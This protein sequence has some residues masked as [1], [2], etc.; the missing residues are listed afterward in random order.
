[1]KAALPDET[2]RRAMALFD[3]LSERGDDDGFRRRLLTGES[4]AVLARVA[5][6]ESSASSAGGMIPT[7]L[8]DTT[9]RWRAPPSQVGAFRVTEL[10]GEGGMG[11][12]WKA[13]RSDGLYD[14]TVAIKVMHAF[15]TG[16]GNQRF[17]AER[18]ILARLEHPHIARLIDGGVLQDGAPFLVMEYVDGLALDVFAKDLPLHRKVELFLQVAEAVQFA[19]ERLVVHADLKPTNILV[20]SAGRTRLLDFGIARLL[21]EVEESEPQALP[22]T[23]AYASPA[24]LDGAPPMVADDVYALGLILQQLIGDVRDAD[25]Q[26]VARVASAADEGQR[27]GSVAALIADL[28][29]WREQW[30]VTAQPSSYTYRASRFLARHRVGV[31]ASAGAMVMLLATAILASISYVRAEQASADAKARFEDVRGT[32]RYLLFD[33]SDR[34]ERQPQSLALR[35]DVA[36]VSQSYLDR[37]AT[38]RGASAEVKAESAEGLRR[39][40]ER[41]AKPGR[42]NLGQTRLAQ[43][44]LE[45]AYL[46][47]QAVPEP[48]GRRLAARIRLDQAR[49]ATMVD[50]DM[51][52]GERFV[53]DARRLIFTPQA[54]LSDL[55]GDYYREV[56][57]LRQWQG[58]YR[59]AIAAARSGL[60]APAPA[61]P[62]AGIVRQASLSDLL[63]EALYYSGEIGA[64]EAPYRRRVQLLE[65]AKERWPADPE[66]VRQLPRSRWALATTLLELNRPA[67]ALPMLDRGLEE[68]RAVALFDTADADA[69][70]ALQITLAARAQALAGVGRISEAVDILQ[71]NA[72]HRR[73]LWE[74]DPGETMR[75]RDYAVGI[76]MLAEVE[77]QA[78]RTAEACRHYLEFE[79]VFTELRTSGRATALDDESIL[80]TNRD[81]RAKRCR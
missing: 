61:D 81:Q 30:P 23:R 34:L 41:Q 79:Q 49:L 4:E 24:R 72:D 75:L 8:P 16:L 71:A 12:V 43:R 56:S 5:A 59:E 14:Q 57:T 76:S 40:A 11:Q 19:H 33:L 69:A 67:E 37:L 25:L 36:R 44:N 26:A 53:A 46:L 70:R 31:A 9:L 55:E 2:E 78:G 47:S 10:V 20:D 52:T 38:T 15:A 18:R 50:I 29:R 45:K 22:M 65:Q 27:Y 6:L 77:H 7:E 42:A 60:A 28:W 74:D 35:A 17:A 63:A 48:E 73:R 64:A 13:V 62:R 66:I 51:E 58:R 3:E 54:P 68:A 80:K 32:A 39:L 21:E 1:M